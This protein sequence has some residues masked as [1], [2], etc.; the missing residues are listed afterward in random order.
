MGGKD[1]Y[2]PIGSY[3]LIGDLHT[4]ALV[5]T[6]GS[7]DFFCYPRF[8]SPS[9]FAALLDRRRGGFFRIAPELGD[10]AR[11]QFYLPDTN[12]LLTRFLHE[13]GVA[14]ILDFMP[15]A[16][17]GPAHRLIRQ[18]RVVRGEI[19][20]RVVCAPRFDYGRA[21]HDVERADGH[22]RFRS[23]GDDGTS[24]R[25]FH[26]VPLEVRDG[27]AVAEFTLQAGETADFALIDGEAPDAELPSSCDDA[28]VARAFEETRD[29]WRSW[30]SRCRYDGRWGEV[31]RRSALALKLLASHRHGSFVAAPTFGLPERIGGERNWDYRFTWIRDA[32][33]TLYGLMRL[34]YTEEA[35]AF[36]KWIAER[37]AGDCD[38]PL[39]ILYGIDGAHETPEIELAHLEGYEGSSPV[40]IGNG[41][42]GQLQLD[43]YGELMDS[44]YLYNKYGEPISYDFW[45]K[46]TPIVD[47]VCEN[48]RREDFGIW[49]VRDGARE[50]T[51]S[52]LMCW[53]A[54]D[55]GLRL[56]SKRS[57]PAPRDRWLA[58]RD[59]IYRDLFEH[60][61][62]PEA[63]AFVQSRG[64]PNLDA[65]VL[66]MPLVK[67]IGPTD[68]R[69]LSTL[70]AIEKELV[71][72]SLVYRY[73]TPDGLPEGEGTFSMCT[74]WYAECLARAGRV[75]EARLVFEKMLGYAN[76]VGLYAEEIGP[77]AEQ[78][79]N[80]PQAF[81]HLGLISAAWN[82]D[83]ALDEKGARA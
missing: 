45:K 69:W 35:G 73:C 6:D 53:V 27:D 44:V 66:L 49:E 61:W 54:V 28:Y 46:L 15:V 12:I 11:K 31:V 5:G 17:A 81:T 39:Q 26:S 2:L 4:V 18:L 77:R 60:F 63:G 43:I 33:F 58:V 3:G 40:R 38:P 20:F 13:D 36:M 51:Y 83:R 65:S 21:D 42:A 78:L 1:A 30:I 47:W 76:H 14:E 68:P 75:E 29:Y 10:A 70:K 62:D 67:F 72:D 52:K 25:L 32:A 24:L 23:R 7:I 74:F 16:E 48:W 34:G 50:F 57:F 41:A 19:R 37:C 64:S 8:D 79:G 9:V 82:L 22:L 80:F 71:S 59:E 56:A 55:R